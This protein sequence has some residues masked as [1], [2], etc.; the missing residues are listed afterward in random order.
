MDILGSIFGSLFVAF[1]L[2]IFN[3]DVILGN[4]MK[5]LFNI[6]ISKDTYYMIFVVFGIVATIIELWVE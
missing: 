6:T 5:E 3:F 1:V 2:T 4:S